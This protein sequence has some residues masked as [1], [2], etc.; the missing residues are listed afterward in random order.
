MPPEI[1]GE[2]GCSEARLQLKRPKCSIVLATFDRAHLL[3]RS[4][5][6]YSRQSFPVEQLELVVID[7]HSTDDT[8]TVV[9]DWAHECNVSCQVLTVGPKHEKWRDAGAILNYGIRAALGEHIVLTH[10]EVMPGRH[11]VLNLV[12][13][14]ESFEHERITG[15]QGEEVGNS[16][17]LY[18]ACKVYY[19]SRSEQ[20]R[21]DSVDWQ[22]EGAFAVRKMP[23]FYEYDSNGH[24]D[25]RHTTTDK[26]ATPGYRLQTW[27]SWVF[28]GCS[29]ETW[30]RLGGMWTTSKWGSVD[31]AFNDRRKQTGMAEWTSSDDESIVVHQNHDGEIDVPTPRIEQAWKTE[32][33]GMDVGKLVYPEVDELVW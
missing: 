31:V 18:A 10:P 33:N 3:K 8:R 26:I 22:N 19:L 7:D 23:G 12:T 11:S 6:C 21:I 9:L 32:L 27:D 30:R 2:N 5:E 14:L 17:G 1:V 25:Y 4:L 15:G 28:A 13:K 16:P 24:P 20:D 29:R